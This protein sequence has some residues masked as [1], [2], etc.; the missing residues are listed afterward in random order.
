VTTL[1]D[2]RVFGLTI[3]PDLLLP[4]ERYPFGVKGGRAGRLIALG[5]A[6]ASSPAWRRMGDA[7]LVVRTDPPEGIAMIG[8]F[9]DDTAHLVECL[10]GQLQ[11]QLPRLRYVSYR[12][13]ETDCEALAARL[14]ELFGW[15]EVQQMFYTA[16]PRGGLCV[17]GMLAYVIGL[18]RDQMLGPGDDD[19]PIVVVDDC[20]LSGFRFGEFLR[21]SP[22][23]DIVFAHL[24]SHPDLRAAILEREPRVVAVTAARDLTDYAP[25]MLGAEYPS[26]KARWDERSTGRE[27]WTGWS[28]HLG[29]PWSEPDLALWNPVLQ[30]EDVAWRVIPPEACLKNRF[31]QN[32]LR[33]E[34]PGR[35]L[36]IQP[37][38]AGPIR[39]ARRTFYGELGGEVVAANLDSRGVVRLSGVAGDIW[40]AVLAHGEVTPALGE[41]ERVYEVEPERLRTDAARL[42]DQ[43]RERGLLI[44][45]TREKTQ[46]THG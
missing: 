8:S 27:Y 31:D 16:I 7:I 34:D 43:L 30:G 25:E 46:S 3:D 10:P 1:R 32:A 18:K 35:R 26:W 36:Q 5:N 14:V 37:P 12:Q 2:P 24:Y 19:R 21:E 40:R 33:A 4:P 41:L 13:A 28:E 42:L 39:V 44:G 45:S 38:A 20:A 9:S 15:Q 22:G 23:R 29:F 6:L 11:S 17:L